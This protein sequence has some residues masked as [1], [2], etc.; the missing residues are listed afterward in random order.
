MG[1][2]TSPGAARGAPSAGARVLEA[3]FANTVGSV[4][5]G[6]VLAVLGGA[7]APGGAIAQPW[8]F[9]A[10]AVAG[11]ALYLVARFAYRRAL[12]RRR[13]WVEH[14]G[15]IWIGR[16]N[17]K[18]VPYC[19]RCAPVPTFMLTGTDHEYRGDFPEF[20]EKAGW[21]VSAIF[22]CPKCARQE[23]IIGSRVADVALHAQGLIAHVARSPAA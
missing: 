1:S 6:L 9:V 20:A 22:R 7:A 14:K 15:M 21:L 10:W 5:A 19:R 11:A 8:N 17:R 16:L 12:R 2:T 4:V 23:T 13:Y 18:P 3:C